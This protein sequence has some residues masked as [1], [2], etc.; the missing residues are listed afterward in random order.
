VRAFVLWIGL[1]SLAAASFALG[2]R[3]ASREP[4]PGD[5]DS[6]PLASAVGAV[7]AEPNELARAAG[8]VPILAPLR[9]RDLDA[10]VSAYEA[11]FTS[12]GP[13]SVAL[14]LLAEAW[15]RIDPQGALDRIGTWARYWQG[16]AL[17][18]LVQSWARRDPRSARDAAASI[19]SPELRSAVIA[20]VIGGCRFDPEAVAT[21]VEGQL[22][23]AQA[24]DLA[25]IVAQW[26]A[27][28]GTRAMEWVLAQ[29]PDAARGRTL[30]V[31]FHTWLGIDREAALTWARGQPD[32]TLKEIGLEQ[33]LEPKPGR[34][35]RETGDPR[36]THL[37]N[38]RSPRR[39]ASRA[40]R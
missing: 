18:P 9:K 22:A 33:A 21:F 16:L 1:A 31:A 37:E 40:R 15:V 32:G 4:L 26:V 25:P 23:S 24:T 38:P 6:E 10:V 29:P 20:A 30:R 36:R 34:R 2:H 27:S 28:D 8:L 19:E 35:N 3:W 13:G 5:V 39:S 7:L 12:V 14:E 17:P 11:T